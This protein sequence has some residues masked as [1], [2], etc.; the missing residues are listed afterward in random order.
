MGQT[1]YAALPVAGDQRALLPAPVASAAP[2]R[3]PSSTEKLKVEN[4]SVEAGKTITIPTYGFERS[5]VMNPQP[6]LILEEKPGEIIIEGK[7][8]GAT[9]ILLW[10]A[11]GVRSIRMT[12]TVPKTEIETREKIAREQ[13][14]LYQSQKKRAFKFFYDTRYSI[15]RD[16]R[17]ITKIS[18]VR[19][20]GDHQMAMKGQTPFGHLKGNLLMEYR[21]DANTRSGVT[22]PSDVKM[23]LYETRLPRM[24]SMDAV[25]GTQFVSADP[26]GFPG[27]RILG[28]SLAP[29]VM[30]LEKAEARSLHPF[31][32][33]GRE[34]D[35]STID[36]PA[37]IRNR[38]L[39]NRFVG[40]GAQYF[41]WK[42]NKISAATYH[43]WDGPQESRADRNADVK[44]DLGRGPVRFAT[45]LGAD[46]ENQ[47]A[48]NSV[49]LLSTEKFSIENR[50]VNV[51]KDYRTVTGSAAGS[52]Q[53]GYSLYAGWYPPEGNVRVY[54]D[55]GLLR[56]RTSPS[57]EPRFKKHYAK[58][59]S[60]RLEWSAPDGST[61]QFGAAYEDQRPVSSP[62]IRKRL[63]GR[64]SKDFYFGRRFFE[65][66]GFFALASLESFRK[67]VNSPGFNANRSGV[68][69]GVNVNIFSGF[70][71]SAQHTV[72]KLSEK[73]PVPPG[74]RTYP[75]QFIVQIDY[76]RQLS[77]LPGTLRVGVRYTN[78]QDT[79]N[80]VQQP[81]S[82][83]D[84]IEG[85]AGLYFRMSPETSFYVDSRVVRLKSTVGDAPRAEFSL[86]TGLRTGL[87]SP[88]RIPQK[89]K[90]E[91]C[92]FKD[93][94]ANGI[95][96]P[97]EP[98]LAGFEVS[99]A[100]G[101]AKKT[102]ENGFYRL[103]VKEGQWVVTAA[104]QVPEGWFFST[105]SQQALELL[106]GE[107]RTIHFGVSAQIQARGRIYLDLNRNSFFD[108][109]DVP[110]AGIEIK[111]ASGQRGRTNGEGLYSIFRVLPGANRVSIDLNSLPSGYRTLSPTEKSFDAAAGDAITYDVVLGADRIISGVV[112]EDK[113]QDGSRGSGEWGVAGIA[114]SA[115]GYKSVTNLDGRFFIRDLSPGPKSVFV[116]EETVP[117]A[118]KLISE[119][120]LIEVPNGPLMRQ[121][122]HFALVRNPKKPLD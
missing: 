47:A 2:N 43:R 25:G 50:W 58:T 108:S 95:R 88:I 70:S 100:G 113:D 55:A 49:L 14:P 109:G 15:Q 34:R 56:S 78:E 44:L 77:P 71:A 89:G 64:Y 52:G 13:S 118:Y 11:A 101:P 7:Q 99:I 66:A 120:Y 1:A 115:G 90:V 23:G 61:L 8:P 10:E 36:S 30:R 111:M 103:R 46:D 75:N 48:L 37:G 20:V 57:L 105:V 4:Y 59:I 98:G 74:S 38:K 27:A 31:F 106:P 22:M 63:D 17:E 96:E 16:G 68:G 116:E 72:Y 83:Q 65:N 92:V 35:G 54:L 18:E 87:L 39:K 84:R 85:N 73:E 122:L 86:V 112:F 41:L 76:G 102:D 69:A 21:K 117:A 107:V 114:V 45:E 67:A 40:A 93:V 53:L 60:P 6:V 97:E 110:M 12:V 51:E 81:F 3:N 19:R 94:N 80:K 28:V 26:Y 29:S 9:L 82:Q 119:P 79:F 24:R 5:L 32:F 62:L 91:G 121:D 42:Q 104:G 33:V